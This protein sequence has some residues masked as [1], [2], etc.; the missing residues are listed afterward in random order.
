MAN[1]ASLYPYEGEEDDDEPRLCCYTKVKY[2]LEGEKYTR[3]NCQAVNPNK[4]DKEIQT[5]E[6]A[7]QLFYQ[8]LYS[9]QGELK[10]IDVRIDCNSKFLNFQHY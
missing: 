5:I 6:Y 4:I 2:K 1:C 3:K 10:D 8:S 9:Y 7:V